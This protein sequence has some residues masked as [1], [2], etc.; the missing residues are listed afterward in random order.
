MRPPDLIPENAD[1]AQLWLT[2]QTQWRVAFGGAVGLDYTAVAECA[3]WLGI[4]LRSPRVWRGM[5]ALER[6]ALREAAE[7]SKQKSA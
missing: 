7:A 1:I 4:E 6:E 3:R 5:Q 2:A